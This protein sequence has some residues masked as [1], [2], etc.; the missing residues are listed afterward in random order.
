MAARAEVS[1]APPVAALSL[2]PAGA[3]LGSQPEED[4]DED[5][6]EDDEDDRVLATVEPD[7]TLLRKRTVP[8]FWIHREYD[9]HTT[10]A[11]TFPPVFVHRT[12]KP[13]HPEKLLH[14]DLSMTFGWYASGV[15]RR[16]WL[17]PIGLFYGT[18]SER[19]TRWGAVPLLMGYSRTGEQFTFG[20]FPFVWWWG[21]KF[22]KNFL[23]VPFH[24]QQ[25]SPEGFRAVSGLLF[26]YGNRNIDD[27]DPTN[28]RRHFVAAPVFWR[29]QRGLRRFDFAFLYMAG[30]NKLTGNEFKAAAP[31]A[32]WRSSEFGNRKELWTLGWVSRIDT[33]RR[34]STWAVPIGLTFRH[35]DPEREVLSAT[36]LFWRTRNHLA[37]SR[38]TLAG[39]VGV[40]EDPRQRNLF[41]APFWYQFHDKGAQATTRVLFPLAVSRQTPDRTSA[42]TLLGGGARSKNGWSAGVPP[43]L[44]FAGKRDDD[45][46][47][48][49]A[50]GLFWHVR[51]P[52]RQTDRWVLAPVGWYSRRENHRRIGVPGLFTS[53]GWGGGRHHQVVTPLFWHV[54]DRENDKRTVVAG[55]VFHHQTRAGY[56]GGLAPL[57]FWGDNE[58]RRYGIVPWIGFA[59]VTDRQN[60]SRLTLSPLF[61]RYADPDTRTLG[62]L[63]LA[64]DVRRP[65]ERHT[66][67]V[68]FY[69]RRQIG[70]RALT[71]T[72]I[73]GRLRT[74]DEI[75][76]LY[77]PYYRRKN[78]GRDGWGVVPLVFND[79]RRVENGIA[80]HT[81]AVPLYL[82]RRAPSDDLDM[83]TPL[84]WR[85]RVR[86]ERPRQG[87]AVV[88]LYFRQ[89]QPQGVDVDAGLGWFFSRDAQ[90][91]T[92]T[93]LAGPAFHRLSRTQ[94][95][96]G[97]APLYWWMDSAEKRR[98]LAFPAIFHFE[99]KGQEHTT[100]AIPFWFDRLRPNGQ[101]GWSA[102][103]VA[104]GFRRL[105]NF[106]RFSLAPPGYIDTFRI[107]R[108]ARFT[109]YVPFLFRLQK[110]GFLDGDDPSCRYTV[111]G[112]A[113]FFLYGSDGQGRRTHGALGLYYWDRRP[114][115]W[116]L[117]TPIAGINNQPNRVLGWYAGPLAVK[118]TNTHRRSMFFPLWYRRAHR[119]RNES[120]TLAVP[121]LYVA[122]QRGDRRFF[123]AGLLVWQFRQPHKVSTAVI[124]P[125]FYHSHAYAQ[126]RLTWV[127]PLFLR[128]NNMGKDETWT[129]LPPLLYLQRRRGE[130]LDVVH[131]PLVW[132][133]ERGDNQ[134]TFGAFVWWDIRARDRIFQWVPAA[135]LRFKG[136]DDRDTRIIGPGLGWWTRD[137][138]E[139]ALHWR[140]LFGLFGGGH[141]QGQRYISIFGARINRGPVPTGAEPGAP[142]GRQARA[143][144]RAERRALAAEAKAARLLERQAR[145]Q[146][147]R[148]ALD[149]RVQRA[150][151]RSEAAGAELARVR[152]AIA[153]R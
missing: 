88:P 104:F 15:E 61:V 98:L 28:D 83:W 84:V 38:F 50:L 55:P 151:A 44:T 78:A 140:A 147:P 141:A 128:D 9:T 130:D 31:F 30:E 136:R 56:D 67:V 125:L 122:R 129:A 133:I 126:R 3:A 76:T 135:Y 12:P 1:T 86:G 58:R 71:V 29:F 64:W 70:D 144:R 123:Q 10:R 120:L 37:G 117:F 77:G 26:W 53:F 132:H 96:S 150:L 42:W 118:T 33:A 21:T 121:P 103:P 89:R 85:S 4:D 57:A 6:D 95:H 99:T 149:R 106:T 93:F 35:R 114:E 152:A 73:G 116:R 25:R 75:T 65:Q 59:D 72:P 124:P 51:N 119:L 81:V 36:P 46:R 17:N 13:D 20:Q 11:L 14:A 34:K 137:P 19:K 139:D 82:R 7:P 148:P 2:G 102:F 110:C 32:V 100:V 54:R 108:N 101:R 5:E 111:W 23:A 66:A 68:P 87:L 109:G 69:Y 113:P 16:R 79:A 112:S 8:P 145:A 105:Y 48:Q 62:V 18:F 94:I 49:T 40:Y 39:P 45:V 43:L 24:Y 97:V 142:Q 52:S 131:F 138:A 143:L 63:G 153:T 115:G 74:G 22:V 47:Y 127:A 60:D 90:R 134:G 80:R 91:R 92:H 107:Q 41:A 27:T 146:R